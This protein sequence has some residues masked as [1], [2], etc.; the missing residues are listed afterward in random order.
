MIISMFDSAISR[1]DR[2]CWIGA[3]LF[4]A[5]CARP[6][7]VTHVE[8]RPPTTQQA[9]DAGIRLSSDPD[10]GVEVPW[11]CG[12]LSPYECHKLAT[13]LR[14]GWATPADPERSILLYQEACE[15]GWGEACYELAASDL[16]KGRHSEE[17]ER[18][19][20]YKKGCELSDFLSCSAIGRWYQARAYGPSVQPG[21]LSQA[22]RWW[23]L[24]CEKG[25]AESCYQVSRL[26]ELG[27]GV[28]RDRR[29]ARVL[30]R[31]AIKLGWREEAG[32][33]R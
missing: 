32:G 5:A 10:A 7:Q 17:Q 29:K 9:V 4:V 16:L 30:R 8:R 26:Y 11:G 1:A 25:D 22:V 33:E 21:D 6:P 18:L 15:R 12:T 19:D 2:R 28:E 27:R 14:F 13:R 20:L 3:A 31:R 23:T 24:G